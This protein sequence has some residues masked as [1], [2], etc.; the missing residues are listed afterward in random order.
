M[1]TSGHSNL[2]KAMSN[3][4][5]TATGKWDLRLKQC[6]LSPIQSTAQTEPRSIQPFLH[7]KVK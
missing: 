6:D 1:K 5:P 4:S 3:P 2:A 7:T